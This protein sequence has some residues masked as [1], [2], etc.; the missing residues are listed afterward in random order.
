MDLA[1]L[2]GLLLG[3]GLVVAAIVLGSDLGAFFDLP[4]VMIV[5]GGTLAA[6]L[7]HERVH[8]VL[9]ALRVGLNAFLD[10][11]PAPGDLL[12]RVIQLAARARKE[13][14][15][16]LEQERIEDPFLAHGIRLGVDGLSPE[17]VRAM[18]LAEVA[19]LKARHVRGQK[20]FKFM[21]STA[22]A[23][24][25]IGTLIGLVQMLQGMSDPKAIGPG[26][27]VALLTTFYGALLAYL[28]LN[29]LAEKLATRTSEE[30]A[31]RSLAILGVESILRGENPGL[32]QSKLESH[33]APS[34][35]PPGRLRAVR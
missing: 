30:V 9:G 2:V 4:S 10:R 33:L 3:F 7:V 19:A 21:G 15:I 34:E 25:M 6:T 5:V 29:P 8:H 14:L 12:P 28:I 18:L 16:A 17:L 24:G 11:R 20:V 26:M 32:I 31:L 1:T 13:G 23:M 35:R 22:P 27:A